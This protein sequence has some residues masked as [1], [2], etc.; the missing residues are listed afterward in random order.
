MERNVSFS[1]R[2]RGQD[3]PGRSSRHKDNRRLCDFHQI[4]ILQAPV[5]GTN[6]KKLFSRLQLSTNKLGVGVGAEGLGSLNGG[7]ESTVND[8]LGQDTEGTGNAEEDGVV[9][10]FSQTIV[11]EK[12]TGVLKQH[13]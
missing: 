4:V 12:N 13:C 3:G 9:A 7:A 6:P 1:K 11:L 10:G 2:K 5:T 8:Q